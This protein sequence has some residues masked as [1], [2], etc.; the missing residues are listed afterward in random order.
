HSAAGR[1]YLQ[2]VE[3]LCDSRVNLTVRN[4]AGFI[5]L[6]RAAYVCHP[7]VAK[8][9]LKHST[10]EEVPADHPLLTA[11]QQGPLAVV[12]HLRRDNNSHVFNPD[13]DAYNILHMAAEDDQL[14]IV[15]LLVEE[16]KMDVHA[17]N[18][19]GDT[20]L[21]LAKRRKRDKVVKYLESHL[22]QPAA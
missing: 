9:L 20:P 18:P 21:D 16:I 6:E 7:E 19:Y 15:Q 4:K 22:Q 3:C 10:G 1:G 14:E 5:P 8:Y 2:I 17:K 13:P 12:Q 11:I